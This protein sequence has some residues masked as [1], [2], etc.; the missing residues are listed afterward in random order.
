MQA[1]KTDSKFF[2]NSGGDSLENRFNSLIDGFKF[3]DILVGYFRT[4]G[5]E[6]MR[7]KLEQ[8]EKIRILVGLNIDKKSFDWIEEARNQ[9]QLNFFSHQKIKE[10]YSE[11]L[12]TEIE[13][14]PNEREVEISAQKFIEFIKSGKLEIRVHPSNIHAKVYIGRYGDKWK[15]DFGKVITGSSNFSKNGLVVQREFNV[16][17]KDR[18]DVEFALDQFEQLWQESIEISQNYIET[19]QTK[20]WLNENIT[21]YQIYLKF[22]YEYFKDE[23]EYKALNLEDRPENF[24]EFRYQAEAVINAKKIVENYDFVMTSP[25]L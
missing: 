3:F 2:T 23:I 6:M 18:G 5:F 11:N 9:G 1:V 8:V 4:S 21:P 20:T 15:G 22:L 14:D 16:E 25:Y 17:L 13:S 7:E 10:K 19:I 24:K 12:I